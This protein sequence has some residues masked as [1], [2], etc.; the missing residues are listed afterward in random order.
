MV[1][2]E[3][4]TWWLERGISLLDSA[5]LLETIN[6]IDTGSVQQRGRRGPERTAVLL[7]GDAVSSAVA[8]E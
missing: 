5:K 2:D 8:Q 1:T 7:G 6:L 4:R 3:A